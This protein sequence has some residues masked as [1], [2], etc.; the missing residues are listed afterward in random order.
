MD[1]FELD[2]EEV[3][4][5]GFVLD[6]KGCEVICFAKRLFLIKKEYDCQVNLV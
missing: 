6:R 5:E 1:L 3:G 4:G 2:Q